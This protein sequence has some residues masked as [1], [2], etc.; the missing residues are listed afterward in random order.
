VP[1]ERHDGS[2]EFGQRRRVVLDQRNQ[3][4]YRAS[5]TLP[6]ALDKVRNVN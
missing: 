1:G 6:G 5:L 4:R 3:P 2:A